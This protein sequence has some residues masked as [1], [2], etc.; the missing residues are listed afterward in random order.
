MWQAA[1]ACQL[2]L[3]SIATKPEHISEGKINS[4]FVFIISILNLSSSLGE[5]LAPNFFYIVFF[6]S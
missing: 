6:V 3:R 1:E 2:K 4:L 5:L